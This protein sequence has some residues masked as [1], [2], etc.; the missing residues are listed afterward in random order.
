MQPGQRLHRIVEA[1]HQD[2]ALLCPDFQ[3]CSLLHISPLALDPRQHEQGV[4]LP[5]QVCAEIITRPE[6]LLRID[7][8]IHQGT[9]CFWPILGLTGLYLPIAHRYHP[10]SVPWQERFGTLS[11]SIIEHLFSFA[12]TRNWTSVTARRTIV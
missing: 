9:Q 5:E 10:C 3:P 7:G 2:R 4:V 1:P 8:Q 11:S 12:R 6:H